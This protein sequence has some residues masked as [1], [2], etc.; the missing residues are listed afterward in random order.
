MYIFCLWVYWLLGSLPVNPHFHSREECWDYICSNKIYSSGSQ[1]PPNF[2]PQKNRTQ[3]HPGHAHMMILAGLAWV[4]KSPEPLSPPW[5]CP[6][7]ETC[8]NTVHENNAL[9]E[10]SSSESAEEEKVCIIEKESPW[11][12]ERKQP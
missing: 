12:A 7:P 11:V 4:S 3:G 1:I 10:V 9:F 6:H 5:S 8:Q 2:T